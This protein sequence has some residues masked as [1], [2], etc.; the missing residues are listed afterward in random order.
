M[1]D[2]PTYANALAAVLSGLA[3]VGTAIAAII[4]AIQK[5]TK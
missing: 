5:R 1:K 4:R 2:F 3:A